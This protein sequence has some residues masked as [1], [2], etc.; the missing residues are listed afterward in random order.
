MKLYKLDIN[1]IGFDFKDKRI[2]FFNTPDE[3]ITY[4]DLLAKNYKKIK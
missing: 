4:K 1:I 2:E 3:A